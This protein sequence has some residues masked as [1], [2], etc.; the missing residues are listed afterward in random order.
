[1]VSG[2]LFLGKASISAKAPINLPQLLGNFNQG[3][4]DGLV[5]VSNL[6]GCHDRRWRNGRI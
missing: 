3:K 6:A 2:V 1:M 5:I 4:G